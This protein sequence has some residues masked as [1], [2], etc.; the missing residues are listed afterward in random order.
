MPL[1]SGLVRHAALNRSEL[2]RR[3]RRQRRGSARSQPG[4]MQRVIRC[5]EQRLGARSK[6]ARCR[7]R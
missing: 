6:S 2:D 3:L 4:T 7:V 5:G 1:N